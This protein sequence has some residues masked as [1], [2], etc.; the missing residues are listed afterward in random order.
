MMAFLEK[1]KMPP[2]MQVPL[3]LLI[4][5]VPE[6]WAGPFLSPAVINININLCLKIDNNHGKHA[7]QSVWLSFYSICLIHDLK[8]N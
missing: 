7:T 4:V 1:K 8:T 5:V 3:V 2:S 6:D